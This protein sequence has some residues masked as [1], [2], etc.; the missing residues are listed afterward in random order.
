MGNSPKISIIVPAYNVEKYLDECIQSIL[1]QDY[2][3]WELVVVDDGSKDSTPAICDKYA[4]Q[5]SRVRVIHQANGGRSEARNAALRVVTG[6]YVAN[7]DGDDTYFPSALS[8]ISRKIV[9]CQYPDLVLGRFSAYTVDDSFTA[10]DVDLDET[11]ID[12]KSTDELL[13]YL[14]SIPF[15]YTQCRYIVKREMFEKFNLFFEKGLA[16][17]DEYWTPQALCHATSYA[18]VIPPFY[19]YRIHAGS[20]MTTKDFKKVMDKLWISRRMQEFQIQEADSP[21]KAFFKFRSEKLA[22]SALTE[23]M[24]FSI[25]DIK[26]AIK[27]CEPIYRNNPNLLHDLSKINN[28]IRLFGYS[29]GIQLYARYVKTRQLLHI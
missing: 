11:K 7:L 25:E 13:T 8:N 4:A 2:E 12:G 16:H 18:A 9:K 14:Q 15:I 23:A 6:D 1:T 20:F 3:N 28:L 26:K 21:K 17:E 5:D 19:S 22:S 10:K 24:A 27:E 29:Y